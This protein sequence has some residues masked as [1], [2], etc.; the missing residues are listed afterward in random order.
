MKTF[1]WRKLPAIADLTATQG[2][3]VGKVGLTWTADP[4]ATSYEIFRSSTSG[5]A[6]AKIGTSTASIFDDT[7]L[8]T[9]NQY[10]YTV[11]VKIGATIGAASNQASGYR[12]L[13]MVLDLS[14]TKGTLTGKV[15]L[16]WSSASEATG[17]EIWRSSVQGQVGALLYALSSGTINTYEDTTAGADTT[18]YYTV[19]VKV[20]SLIGYP[21]NEAAGWGKLP[22]TIS[23]LTA[24]QGTLIGNVKL[25]WLDDPE[26]T[27]YEIY[28]SATSGGAAMKIG[29]STIGGFD[30]TNSGAGITYYYTVKT[31]VASLVGASSNEASGWGKLPDAINSLSA[32]QGTL[33][34]KVGLTWT[35][36]NDAT[37][38]EIVRSDTS[39]G[40][41]TLLS[42]VSSTSYYDQTVTASSKYYYTVKVKVG[43]LAS[44]PSNEAIGWR[45]LP[46]IADL[47]ATQGTL[48]GK[49]GLTWTTDPEA[50]G[51]EIFRSA[52]PGGTVTK[53]GTSTT[54]TFYDTTTPA[55]KPYYYKVVIKITDVSG[56]FSNEASGYRKLPLVSDLSATKGMLTGKVGLAW[57]SASEATGYEIWRSPVQGQSGLLISSVI[58]TDY[59]DTTAGAGT[60]YYYT[61]K[62]KVGS[63]IG[64][65]GNEADGW[66][67]LPNTLSTLSAT[68]GSLI[69]KVQLSWAFDTEA[70]SYEIW[71]SMTQGSGYQLLGSSLNAAYEDS[72]ALDPTPYYYK[73]K[74]KTAN[75]TGNPSNEASGWSR[76]PNAI[77]TLTATQGGFIAKVRLKWALDKEATHYEVWRATT[78][79]G[80][81]SLLN[82]LPSSAISYDDTAIEPDKPYYYTVKV[83]VGQ[84]VGPPSNEASGFAKAI[85]PAP[86]I[87][88]K[89]GVAI[90]AGKFYVPVGQK[91][92]SLAPSSTS[93]PTEKMKITM[94]QNGETY[95]RTDA[96]SGV[97]YPISAPNL[98]L[99]EERAIHVRVAWQNFPDVYNE[100]TITAVGGTKNNLKLITET[101]TSVAD[102]E[103]LIVKLKLGEYTKNGIAYDPATMGQWQ[104][105][106]LVQT[107]S[108]PTNSPGTELINMVN[109][110]AE[111]SLNPAG[112]QF[113][114]ITAVSRLVSTVPGL[115][116]NLIASTKYVQVVKG[117][118]IEGT[119]SSKQFDAPAPKSFTLNLE[120]SPDN[121]VALKTATWEESSDNGATWD[122]I[123]DSIGTRKSIL[124]PDPERKQVRAKM[125]N[126]NTL[127]ESYTDPVEL[128]AYSKLTV[129]ITGPR[130]AAPGTA[131]VLSADVY[132]DGFKINDP[133]VEWTVGYSA[134]KQYLSGSTA[135]VSESQEGKLAVTMR[136]RSQDTRPDDVNAWAYYRYVV[137][138]KNPGAPTLSMTGPRDVETGKTY[139]YQGAARPSWGGVQSAL[140]I[141]SE[142]ELP[143]GSISAGNG[144]DWTPSAQEL[145]NP[146]PLIFRAWV[147]GFKDSTVSERTLTYSPWMYVWPNFTVSLKQLTV[148]APSDIALMV[149]HDQ[150]AMSRRFEGLTYNWSFPANMTG[151]QNDAFPNRA[152]AQALY[153]G[154]YDVSVTIQDTR[155]HETV[156]TQHIVTEQA[157]PYAITLKVGKSNIYDRVPMTVT[158]RPTISDGHPLDSV[159]QQTWKIDNQTISDYTNRNFLYGDIPTPGDHVVSYTMLSKM[160]IE[161]IATATLSLVPNEPPVCQLYKTVNSL[162]V[163]VDAK[164]TDQDGKVISYS[165]EVDG[166]PIGSTSYRISFPKSTTPQSATVTIRGMDDA[167]DLSAP[168]SINVSY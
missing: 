6:A 51:Y 155:G 66:G 103:P 111:F 136:A 52:T 7:T 35:K 154:E 105:Q 144:L 143:D 38:Y 72:T 115:N 140:A 114:K 121:R 119:I 61:I 157:A 129:F 37:A 168:V 28:R 102:T 39:G 32:T 43:T 90:T 159:S 67:K 112:N 88:F 100:Q 78:P 33:V 163:Y 8:T 57:S 44:P 5:G 56:D 63:L 158:V 17:Y 104:T 130:H 48:D 73:V 18:Y 91:V 151:R 53:I 59:E 34:G 137:T 108:Q 96:L 76:L 142:W 152:A 156:L 98:G 145:A 134:G 166:Q 128:L 150:P 132:K 74:I 79:Q 10:Y 23:T 22:N 123:P 83:K 162:S 95:E 14:T 81:A 69:G 60:T 50:T 12:K 110:Q 20:G 122:A 167:K 125:V 45:K 139:H 21:G 13:P 94:T 55:S 109:G 117:T 71:R 120:M 70:V 62:T 135:S 64:Y 65:I 87:N 30:D 99:L 68:Q 160:G 54:A 92:T 36:N 147:D 84:L 11:K 116:V 9:S 41:T 86:T 126:K 1:G 4:E 118:P 27:S 97:L 124:M 42:S 146:K 149:N 19:K 82:T 153:A 113:M 133:I 164:C 85:P 77:S 31:V 3:L 2:T 138:F 89:G 75:L 161:T 106:L 141:V 80:V 25:T 131:A 58:A 16:A 148:Q 93:A 46:V 165:W 15:G 49:V 40:A 101:P 29:T 24:T 26:A 107:N 127:V 47:T